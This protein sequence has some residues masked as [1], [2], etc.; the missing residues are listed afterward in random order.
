MADAAGLPGFEVLGW[1]GVVAPAGTPPAV[2][3]K[4]NGEIVRI[5]NLP[6]VK[7]RLS[8]QG[9]EPAPS[10]PEEFG[11]LIRSDT[12]KWAKVIKST[13]MKQE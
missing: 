11:R 12:A 4:I 5:L 3:A 9:A 10:T 7:Q 6:D 2:I 13:G 8:E 1:F